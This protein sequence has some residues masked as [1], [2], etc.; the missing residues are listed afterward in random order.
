MLL[1]L[2][3]G[4]NSSLYV[5]FMSCQFMSIRTNLTCLLNRLGFLNVNMTCLLN[6]LVVPNRLSNFCINS[7]DLNYEKTKQIDFF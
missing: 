3:R 7:I 5:N 6:G 2:G 4:G 1:I